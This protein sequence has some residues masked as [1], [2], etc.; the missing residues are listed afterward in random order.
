MIDH[1]S[2][3]GPSMKLCTAVIVALSAA[4]LASNAFAAPK[5][6]PQERRAI[7]RVVDGFVFH[8]VRHK[9]PAAAYDLVSPTFRAGMSR[10]EFARNDPAYPYPARGRHYPWSLDYVDPNEVGG[11]LLLQPSR[12]ANKNLGPILF[13]L[14]V[15]RHQ[16]RWVVESLIPKVTFGPP[17]KPK[18]RSVLDFSPQ[19]P[20]NGPTYDR[21]RIS[22]TY[23]IIPFAAFGALL[24]GLASWGVVRWYRDR[25]IDSASV[26]AR[27]TRARATH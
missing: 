14:R 12:K 11:S 16:G 4:V 26:R 6:S 23:I 1:R 15:I 17:N 3:Y 19:T 8:A 21:S 27:D 24:L 7:N 9:N 5:L 25:R 20:G 18:V 2:G 22:G 10:A 13:D